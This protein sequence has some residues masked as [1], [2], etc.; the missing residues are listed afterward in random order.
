MQRVVVQVPM[1]KELK[2]KAEIVSA[3]LGFSSIQEAIRVL[4][5][6]L[7]KREFSLR[8]E[9]VEQPNKYFI[10]AMKKAKQN[11][12]QGKGSPIFTNIKDELKWLK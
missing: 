4:L 1:A 6:K 7:S 2:N 3:D 9:E 10:S 5:T 8:V 11:R 12:E